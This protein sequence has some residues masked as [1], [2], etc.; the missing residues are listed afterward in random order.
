MIFSL[1]AAYNFV[2]WIH[3]RNPLSDIPHEY[4]ADNSM[5]ESANGL[6]VVINGLLLA[7]NIW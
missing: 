4:S 1:P 7:F 3:E 6:H 5:S 2:M